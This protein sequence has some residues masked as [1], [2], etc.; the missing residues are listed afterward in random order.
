M[1][2]GGA[3]AVKARVGRNRGNKVHFVTCEKEGTRVVSEDNRGYM[4][5]NK[6][7]NL[8]IIRKVSFFEQSGGSRDSNRTLF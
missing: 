1:I 4:V 7:R 8:G 6:G 2:G 5:R 3:N